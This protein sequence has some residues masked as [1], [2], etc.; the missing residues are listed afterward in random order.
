MPLW[1]WNQP[2]NPCQAS[3]YI[4]DG[5]PQSLGPLKLKQVEG[6]G[7]SRLVC[8]GILWRHFI[9]CYGQL[10]MICG[11]V[12]VASRIPLIY[13]HLFPLKLSFVGYTGTVY[14]IFRHTHI[15]P[16]EFLWWCLMQ[17]HGNMRCG[18]AYTTTCGWVNQMCVDPPNWLWTAFSA[19]LWFP[20]QNIWVSAVLFNRVLISQEI[21]AIATA[22]K[23]GHVEASR[24]FMYL[25]LLKG[26]Y[27]LD[28]LEM[29][30][31]IFFSYS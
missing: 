20:C 11:F 17:F 10:K 4:V 5:T 3:D 8:Y 15:Y 24:I 25:W 18:G 23:L 9:S 2:K 21:L 30:W 1:P 6:D 16:Y 29:R 7:M 12:N 28:Y 27:C 31:K 22:P 13:H 14:L 26:F 19:N